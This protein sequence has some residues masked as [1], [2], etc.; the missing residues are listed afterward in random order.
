MIINP[1]FYKFK[2]RTVSFYVKKSLNF[3]LVI[4]FRVWFYDKNISRK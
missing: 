2:E 3:D 1:S 4:G